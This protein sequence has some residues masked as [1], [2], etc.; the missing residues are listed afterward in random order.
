MSHHNVHEI[1][2]ATP[3][4][5]KV[6]GDVF[7]V[8]FHTAPND[9]VACRR[10]PADSIAIVGAYYLPSVFS[11][12]LRLSGPSNWLGSVLVATGGGANNVRARP[13]GRDLKQGDG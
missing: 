7:A 6:S 8:S 2:T 4:P 1:V 3:L 12:P 9:K 10:L 11:A 5:V 13:G